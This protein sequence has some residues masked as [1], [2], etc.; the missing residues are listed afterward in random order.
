MLIED[1]RITFRVV[2][3]GSSSVGKTSIINKFLHD[4]FNDKEPNTVGALY[5]SFEDERNGQQMAIQIWDTAGEER[6]RSVVP[7][8]FRNSTGAVLVFDQTRKET[9]ERLTDWIR[10]YKETNGE[11]ALFFVAA[12][13][14]D[15]MREEGSSPFFEDVYDWASHEGYP[16]YQTSAK[17]GE[18]VALMVDEI[19]RKV[20]ETM[21]AETVTTKGSNRGLQL[22]RGSTKG[23][24]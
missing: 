3:I 14:S 12:N 11:E 5:E 23:C 10:L 1:E 15:L 24:C 17:T 4:K 6:F 2:V 22:T 20:S 18:G 9:F 21:R 7:I 16:V 8:Y 19:I 13:K